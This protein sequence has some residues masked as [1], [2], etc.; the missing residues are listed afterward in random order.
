MP[1]WGLHEKWAVKAGLDLDIARRIDRLIDW[2]FG[3]H[4][5]GRKRVS[6]CRDFL[7]RVVLPNYS[8][9]GAASFFLHHALDRIASIT[10]RCIIEAREEGKSHAEVDFKEVEKLIRR[11]I[12]FRATYTQQGRESRSQPFLHHRKSLP[13]VPRAGAIPPA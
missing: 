11:L 2:E 6:E 4:D 5:I 10:R 7:Y 13:Q 12:P 9:E 8:Y 3:H 1:S